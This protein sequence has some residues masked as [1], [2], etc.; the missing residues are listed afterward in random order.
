[1]NFLEPEIELT[2]HCPKEK[3]TFY[4]LL[5]LNQQRK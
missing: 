3:K 4:F 2:V 1:M 5:L